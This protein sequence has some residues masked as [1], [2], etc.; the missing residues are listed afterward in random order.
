MKFEELDYQRTPLG[1]LTLW[2]REVPVSGDVIY[3]VRLAGEFLMSSRVNHSE[4]ALANLALT[5]LGDQD[6]DVLI[7]GLGLGHTA[8]AALAFPNVRSVTVIEIFES[9]IDWHRKK[10]VPLGAELS[11]DPRCRLLK[12]DFFDL[13]GP[14]EDESTRAETYDAILV[15]IDHSTEDLLQPAHAR[16]YTAIG[17]AALAGHLRPGGAFSFWSADRPREEFIVNLRAV[18]PKVWVEQVTFDN[19]HL[20]T[21]DTN[22]ILL[23]ARDQ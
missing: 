5:A 10:M 18:F 12:A 13:I 21:E 7:G 20:G 19:P 1:E 11:T 3:E 23:A 8:Q 2:R 9:I 4:I 6:C 16:F 15:D 17:V 22:F 14:R